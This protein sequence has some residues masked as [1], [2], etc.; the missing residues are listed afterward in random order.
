MVA[1][2]VR[3][4]EVSDHGAEERYKSAVPQSEAE[5]GAPS[6][7]QRVAKDGVVREMRDGVTKPIWQGAPASVASRNAGKGEDGG[8]MRTRRVALDSAKEKDGGVGEVGGGGS[9]SADEALSALALTGIERRTVSSPKTPATELKRE[10]TVGDS[11]RMEDTRGAEAG[12][13]KAG[14]VSVVVVG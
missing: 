9:A 12:R 4:E 8:D 7:A 1:E 11:M 6:A 10:G 2:I 14:A 5:G 3:M 13:A